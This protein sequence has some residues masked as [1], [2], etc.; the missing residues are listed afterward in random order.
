MKYII[1][2]IFFA[3]LLGCYNE[4][5]NKKIVANVER[6][7]I[8]DDKTS[9]GIFYV[10]L[11]KNNSNHDIVLKT[12]SVNTDSYFLKGFM[13]KNGTF[14]TPIGGYIS[15]DNNIVLSKKS[16]EKFLL[17]YSISFDNKWH[18]K[19]ESMKKDLIKLAEFGTLYFESDDISENFKVAKNYRSIEYKK[20]ITIKESLSWVN[21]KVIVE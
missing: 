19:N 8:S 20:H 9:G 2:I 3:T 11:L 6:V 16:S 17:V 10:I 14:N 13:L 12:N 1:L 21:G 4:R 18:I 15:K 5:N 7:V